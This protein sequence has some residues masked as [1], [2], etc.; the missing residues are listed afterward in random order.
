[1]TTISSQGAVTVS[2]WFQAGRWR[3]P[4]A[5]GLAATLALLAGLIVTGRLLHAPAGPPAAT[6]TAPAAT[7][8]PYRAGDRLRCPLRRP[9]LVASDGRSYPPGH[10]TRPPG[11]ATGVACYDT[12]EQ[13]AAAGHPQAPLPAGVVQV[14]GVYLLPTGQ[15]WR[16]G[17]RRAADRVGFA[18]P[19]P[20]LLPGQAPG[21]VPVRPCV[22]PGVCVRGQAFLL[23]L[24]GFQVPLGYVGVDRQAVG[25]LEVAAAPARRP[26]P[27]PFAE[28]GGEPPATTVT[29]AGSR[30]VLASC[31]ESLAGPATMVRFARAGTLVTLS[32]AGISPVN[33]RLALALA[34]HIRLVRPSP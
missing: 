4:R 21:T 18:V 29:V 30:A 20:G 12:A 5:L 17:C 11:G 31:P 23:R 28:C 25:S 10:P 15:G 14:A 33:Q 6:P 1:M 34:G 24:G 9:V 8:R 19:C 32:L 16:T 27:G 22:D 3:G 26:A 7:D 13:A 2:E